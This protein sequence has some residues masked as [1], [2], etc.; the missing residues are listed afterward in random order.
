MLLL[1]SLELFVK[2]FNRFVIEYVIAITANDI[3]LQW[4]CIS[5]STNPYLLFSFILIYLLLLIELLKFESKL[6]PM[7]L[8]KFLIR[9]LLKAQTVIPL[10]VYC[11]NKI[12]L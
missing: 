4:L 11:F 5:H 7:L 1:I 2:L 9:D 3:H 6:L 12:L 10:V 8:L